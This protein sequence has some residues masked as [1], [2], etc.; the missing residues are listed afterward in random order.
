MSKQMKNF[1]TLVSLIIVGSFLAFL[2][3]CITG[4]ADFSARINPALAPWVFWILFLSV[5]G[6]LTYLA[7]LAF[8]RP[9]PMMVYADPSNEDLANFKQELVRRLKKNRHL[10]ESGVAVKTEA[11]LETGLAALKE[12]ADEEI[13]AT[14]RRVFVG[15]AVSQNGRLDTLV[16][17]YLITRLTWRIAKL[18]NQRPHHRELINLYANIAATSFLAG[19]IE[20]FGIEEYIRELMGPLV[21]GSAIGAVPGAQAIASTITASVLTGSTNS[22]LALRCGVVARDYVSLNLD[23][24]GAMRR[25]A[26]IE[27]S[28][29][30]VSMSAE[31]V[32]YVTKAL[33]KGSAG[34]VKSG[35][36]KA[37]KGVG[38][39]IT[40]TADIV[41]SGAKS[42]GRGI[43]GTA[44]SVVHGVDTAKD[45]AKNVAGRTLDK[46][47]VIGRDVLQVTTNAKAAAIKVAQAGKK[48]VRTLGDR[49]KRLK[50]GEKPQ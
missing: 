20:E 50:R 33:V 18:Y 16:V 42:V 39:T 35:T 34:A 11:D 28:K 8:M 6:M 29:M 4:L 32:T 25:S 30:F 17:L 31:T 22:L 36:A 2:Y 49:L 1:L 21:G 48:T 26:T 27:A 7:T 12:T 15:T 46:A 3:N 5:A 24:K 13:L 14:A 41:G 19:S 40:G 23:A 47:K 45:V 38:S 10:K 37:V 9:K 43:K 44:Q